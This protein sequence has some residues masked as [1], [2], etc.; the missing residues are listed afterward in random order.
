MRHRL[1]A[2]LIVGIS[3]AA[4]CTAA[5][6]GSLGAPATLPSAAELESQLAARHDAVHSVRALAH[7]RYR[8]PEQSGTAREAILVERPDRLRVEVFSLLGSV[9]L[10]TTNAGA[11][12]VYARQDNTVY[13]GAASPENLARYARVG[14]PV[15][16]LI[17][18]VL[19]TPAPRPADQDRVSFDTVRGAVRLVR[20]L[21]DR[22]QS[23][24]FSP[25]SLPVAVEERGADGQLAWQAT[26]GAY[27]DHGGVPIATQLNVELPR[28]SRSLELALRDV[29]VNPPLDS[30][31]FAFHTPPGSKEVT[32]ESIA[33]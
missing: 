26:F 31:L 11:I 13:R 15:S 25:A 7:L 3:V 24:W 23:V 32:L 28:W 27:E 4:G 30:A 9:F 20:T 33:D 29:D 1:R 8:D 6:P 21:A 17:D 16:D 19:A 18:L 10:V 14:L 5:R 2:A 22:Q 12:T